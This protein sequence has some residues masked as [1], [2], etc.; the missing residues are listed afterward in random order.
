MK[1]VLIVA[2]LLLCAAV[3]AFSSFTDTMLNVGLTGSTS[4]LTLFNN[5]EFDA[6]FDIEASAD[7]AMI[8]DNGP[9]F[10]VS[11]TTDFQSNIVLGAFYAHKIDVRNSNLDILLSAGPT[12]NLGGNFA[13]GIDAMCDLLID[14]TSS[15][16]VDLG[17]GLQ[18]DVFK[19]VNDKI[20]TEFN[21]T[22]PLPS[23]GIGV[24]F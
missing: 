4:E 10:D 7:F 2:A 22:I 24:K 5:S 16:Y 18:M 8:F 12:F 20:N 15:V 14:L 9:G 23:V 13:M 6:K 19:I 21:M 17:V 1:K 11:I 3:P